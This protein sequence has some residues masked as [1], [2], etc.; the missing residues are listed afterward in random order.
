MEAGALLAGKF[1]E[2]YG[3]YSPRVPVLPVS[4]AMLAIRG[5]SITSYYKHQLQQAHTEP[6]YI[7]HLQE[8]FKWDDVI[9]ESISWKCLSI[10]IWRTRR[11]VL[12]T[13]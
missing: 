4:S 7:E 9:T 5:V 6:R 10:A 11:E 3:W 13:K 2:D 1:Q 8:K 12:V